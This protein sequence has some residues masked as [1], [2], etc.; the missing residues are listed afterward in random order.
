[1]K[2]KAGRPKLPHAKEVTFAVRVSQNDANKIE[3]A[4][5]TSGIAK[6]EWQRRALVKEADAVLKRP[7]PAN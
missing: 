7:S 6:S 1:M 3:Q 4:I 5:K 2:S